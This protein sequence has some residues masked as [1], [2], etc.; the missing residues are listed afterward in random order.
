MAMV[1]PESRSPNVPAPHLPASQQAAQEVLRTAPER[2]APPIA[3]TQADVGFAIQFRLEF[4]KQLLTIATALLAFSVGFFTTPAAVAPAAARALAPLAWMG[5][6]FLIVSI[7][8]GLYQLRCWDWFYVSYR[9]YDH[10][11]KYELGKAYR[12][13]VTYRRRNAMAVQFATLLIGILFVA[14]FAAFRLVS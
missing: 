11:K 12:K 10:D 13:G 5:W 6:G 3:A 14:I 2:E 1:P 4:A 7:V 8:L 9:D